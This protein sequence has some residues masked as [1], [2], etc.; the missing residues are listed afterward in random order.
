LPK[1]LDHLFVPLFGEQ[2]A[3]IGLEVRGEPEQVRVKMIE[4]ISGIVQ[5][6]GKGQPIPAST[7][8]AFSAE[9]RD[10][11]GR[12][13]EF[14][15][16]GTQSCSSVE[17]SRISESPP[18]LAWMAEAFFQ[19]RRRCEISWEPSLDS[20]VAN[21]SSASVSCWWSENRDSITFKRVF[22]EP[23]C[24]RASIDAQLTE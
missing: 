10:A 17:A 23:D 14:F 19:T 21:G 13:G 18:S 1:E 8:V 6:P 12:S 5:W 3:G 4:R 24:E 7:R 22:E 20:P 9:R 2:A 16:M 11:C 15:S